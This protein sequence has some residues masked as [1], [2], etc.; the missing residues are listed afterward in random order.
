[1]TI[2]M[3]T[4]KLAL[5]TALLASVAIAAPLLADQ[6]QMETFTADDG[7]S[8]FALTVPPIEAT[9][10]TPRDVVVLVDTSASQSGFYRDTAIAALEKCIAGL[11]Q[12]DRV[13]VVAVDLDARAMNDSLAG[14]D[15][16]SISE[17]VEKIRRE[18]PL[19]STDMEL[20]LN[21]AAKLF[22]GDSNRPRTIVYIGD[23]M[24]PANLMQADAFGALVGDLRDKHISVNSFAVGPQRDLELL[25]A[26]A[27]QTGGNI[28]IDKKMVWPNEAE[29]ITTQRALQENRR[30]GG[31][32]GKALAQ[33]AQADVVFPT[34][35]EW[36]AEFAAAYPNQL[37]PIRSDRETI[38][39]GELAKDVEATSLSAKVGDQP[40]NWTVKKAPVSGELSYLPQLV[41]GAER[42]GGLALTTLGT[43]GLQETGRMMLA[44]VEELTSLA[45]RAAVM[46]D[47]E[48]AGRIIQTVLRRDP[49]NPRAKTVQALIESD[50]PIPAQ[51]PS[52][53]PE[54]GQGSS[55]SGDLD[56]VRV[57]Q[58]GE[59]VPAPP[60]GGMIVGP[61]SGEFIDGVPAR[62][63]VVDG[64]YLTEVER[65]NRIVSE[66]MEKEVELTISDARAGTICEQTPSSLRRTSS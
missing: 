48:N 18:P 6:A 64:S 20:A 44:S 36:P 33:W 25:A 26:L 52:I 65:Q 22:D 24:S 56:L 51:Q 39:V 11:N 55:N 59:V 58:A 45:E 62:D 17:A 2:F 13:Q 27:N 57:A 53:T 47:K 19:G 28:F 16:A 7:Q 1:M 40:M 60:A 49:G 8:F 61:S 31:V 32:A 34:A 38:V 14:K 12:A 30:R 9:E 5:S 15:D 41:E 43:R 42:D 46:G 4:G 35:T 66:M 37:L 3:N 23:G 63:A 29:G 50:A 10:P 54:P 21:S